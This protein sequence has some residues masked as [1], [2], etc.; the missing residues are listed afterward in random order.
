MGADGSHRQVASSPGRKDTRVGGKGLGGRPDHAGT[1]GTMSRRSIAA[2]LAGTVV[3]GTVVVVA[4]GLT[5]PLG[6]AAQARGGR[7]AAARQYLADS[8]PVE[9]ASAHF[10]ATA[11]SWVG[12]S[13][14]THA[15]AASAARP[16]I[17]ALEAMHTKLGT[18][19]WPSSTR[20]DV[21][22]L[23]TAASGLVS[24]LRAL[25][26]ADLAKTSSWEGPLLHGDLLITAAA[27]KVR[28]DLGL[29]RLA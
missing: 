10:E 24:D 2:A 26:R 29:P 3:A 20:H 21:T 17:S 12:G 13:A 22:V 15:E 16:L 25:S 28:R 19:R 8:T 9:A 4:S 6:A 7:S 5:G 14:V 11:L 1:E 23:A 18:Q 27:N